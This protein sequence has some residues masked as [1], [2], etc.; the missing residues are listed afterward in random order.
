M[1][2]DLKIWS[3]IVFALPL[4]ISIYYK[5]YILTAL[6][7][8][9]SLFSVLYHFY[10]EKKWKLFDAIFSLLIIAYNLYLCYLSNFKFPYFHIALV[11]AIFS[12]IFYSKAH[13]NNYQLNHSLWHLCS[14]LITIFCILAYVL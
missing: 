9:V 1:R 6:I 8:T 7:F 12:F 2:R 10:N 3:N 4:I 13:K 14:S 5:I 11:F